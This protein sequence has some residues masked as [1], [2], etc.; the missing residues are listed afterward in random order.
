MTAR[1]ELVEPGLATAD[2]GALRGGRCPS[3]TET[4]FPLREHCPGCGGPLAALALPAEGT[5]WTFT[6]L[7]A[8]APSYAGPVP[9]AL[10]VVDLGE[11][12][13]TATLVADDPDTIRI[14]DRAVF[15]LADV[16]PAEAPRSTVG[17]RVVGP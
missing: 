10:G 16:G 4:V 2:A 9:Y 11:V 6:V 3:C 12:R 7:R 8:A 14:G 17:F 5:V 1:P 13:V 15:S